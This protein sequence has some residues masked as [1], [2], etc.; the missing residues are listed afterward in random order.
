[1]S[2]IL[3]SMDVQLPAKLQEKVME[4]SRGMAMNVDFGPKMDPF[5][6]PFC[7]NKGKYGF[8]KKSELVRF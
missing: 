2:H 8:L 6:G 3:A 4:Q 5:W 1:M 7:P